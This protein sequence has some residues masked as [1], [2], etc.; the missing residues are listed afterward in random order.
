MSA[1]Y[2]TANLNTPVIYKLI[3]LHQNKTMSIK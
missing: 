3:S 2:P 1:V